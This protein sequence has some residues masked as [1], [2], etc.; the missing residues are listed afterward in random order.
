MTVDV[1]QEGVP[2]HVL[3]VSSL[4]QL[5]QCW[6]SGTLRPPPLRK[7]R[8]GK[9]GDHP[10]KGERRKRAGRGREGSNEERGER[11]RSSERERRR[12]KER[13]EIEEGG[14]LRRRKITTNNQPSHLPC[15]KMTSM[16][17]PWEIPA[18]V[19]P[20]PQLLS[21]ETNQTDIHLL[22]F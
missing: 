4:H 19:S 6:G 12:E 21:V 9:C 5:P 8:H 17:W 22:N 18:T 13:E 15:R 3:D 11:G 7:H 2:A 20:A 16:F 10:G 1:V 14:V